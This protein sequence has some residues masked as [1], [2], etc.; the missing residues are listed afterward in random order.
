LLVDLLREPEK[1]GLGTLILLDEAVWY[2]RAAVNHDARRLGTL[3]DFF[4][5]LIQAVVKVNRCSLVATLIASAVEARDATGALVLQALEDEF[6]RYEENFEPVAKE[7][8]A[9]ILRRR[10]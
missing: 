3:K 8:L 10:L 6:R 5:S 2:Y 7:D 1:Q 9:E 4:H